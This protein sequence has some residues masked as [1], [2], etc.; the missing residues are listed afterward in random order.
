[1]FFTTLY[2]TDEAFDLD[3]RKASLLLLNTLIAHNKVM[4]HRAVDHRPHR[5]YHSDVLYNC[6]K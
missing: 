2:Q 1:M 5:S 4:Y 6:R 3:V